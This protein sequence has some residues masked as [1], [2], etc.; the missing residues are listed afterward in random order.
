MDRFPRTH[1]KV[2]VDEDGCI[3]GGAGRSVAVQEPSGPNP[4]TKNRIF[5]KIYSQTRHL[6]RARP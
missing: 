5:Y 3:G 1:L 2:V 6:L 4:Q